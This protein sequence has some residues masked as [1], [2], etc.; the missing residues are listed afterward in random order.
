MKVVHLNTNKLIAPSVESNATNNRTFTPE[1]LRKFAGCE[2]YTD[3]QAKQVIETLEKLCEIVYELGLVEKNHSN[4][5]QQ[6]IYLNSQNSN[7][8][9]AA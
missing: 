4:D 3:E 7:Q 5:N 8:L 9:K 2:N 6:V 1:T